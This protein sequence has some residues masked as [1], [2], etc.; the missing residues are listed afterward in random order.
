MTTEH[1]IHPYCD[2]FPDISK[3]E[4]QALADDIDANGQHQ[5]IYRWN[6]QII[7]GKNRFRAC[8]LAGVTPLFESWHPRHPQD[9]D[10]TDAEILSFALSINLTRRHLDESQRAMIAARLRTLK[11]GD[12]QHTK[13]EDGSAVPSSEAAKRLDV[14]KKS[15]DRASSVLKNG[16]ASLVHAVES[17][18]VTIS[19][20]A[21]VVKL[22]KSEQNKAVKA[23]ESGKSPTVAKAA[24]ID[25]E[26]DRKAAIMGA[27]AQPERKSQFDPNEFDAAMTVA[28]EDDKPT[29]VPKHLKEIADSCKEFSACVSEAGR[30]K[31]RIEKLTAGPGGGKL[32]KWWT[33]IDRCLS[34]TQTYL[35][36]YRFWAACPECKIT[37]KHTKPAKDCKLCGGHGWI[38]ESNGLSDIH[39]DWL[40]ERGVKC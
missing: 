19:D 29:N 12:N 20:A 30:L 11:H 17:G 31:G 36:C 39:K 22:P 40:R 18:E 21:K 32:A 33:D 27:Q 7:D 13:G 14:S 24:G 34:Q 10:A 3:D 35:K 16:S 15:V 26:A 37:D 28:A 25:P 38:A 23:V 9:A 5:P 4:L 6:D 1:A 2:L 8:Q